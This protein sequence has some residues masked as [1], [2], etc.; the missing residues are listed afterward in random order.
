MKIVLYDLL[1]VSIALVVYILVN[2]VVAAY[3]VYFNKFNVAASKVFRIGSSGLIGIGAIVFIVFSVILNKFGGEIWDRL[4]FL[5]GIL[6]GAA[7]VLAA[8]WIPVWYPK[9]TKQQKMSVKSKFSLIWRNYIQTVCFALL[10]Y[11]LCQ[12]VNADRLYYQYTNTRWMLIFLAIA[13]LMNYSE[14]QFANMFS[15]GWLV[16]GILGSSAYLFNTNGDEQARMIARLNCGV[17]VAWGLLVVNILLMLAR[18]RKFSIN[19]RKDQI[20][21]IHIVLLFV[22]IVLMYINRFEKMW[23]YTAT[24]PFIALLFIK[25]K[26]TINI[27]FLKNFTNGIFLS[28]G[29]VTLF[30]VIH[31]PH[32]Y[33]MLYRYGGLFHTV[34]CTG[35]YLAVVFGAA[36]AKLYGKIKDRKKMFMRCPVEYFMVACAVSFILLTMSKTALFTTIMTVAAIVGL[37]AVAYHKNVRRIMAEIGVLACVCIISFPMVFTVV[38]TVPALINDPIRYDIEFQDQSFMVYEGDPIDSEKYMTVRRFFSLFFGRFHAETGK[39]SALGYPGIVLQEDSL[40]AY[41]GQSFAG[42]D[43]RTANEASTSEKTEDSWDVSNGRFEIFRAYLKEI[44][45]QG[46]PKM[47]PEDENGSEYA[48][49]HNSYLQVAYNFGV[50]AGCIFLVLCA[51]AL[52]KA[53]VLFYKQGR[54]FGILLVPFSLLVAFGVVSLTE[55]AFHP[56]IPLGFCFILMQ[57]FLIKT[58]GLL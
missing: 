9:Q 10:F 7:W 49:A 21:V 57:V 24:L 51:L 3:D 6:A 40:L 47:G 4:F 43:M 33:W 25:G 35:M 32:H 15:L 34:A 20:R 26:D 37:T 55:W 58:E 17:T 42:I 45:L 18:K 8:V 1:I 54:K 27:R 5:T 31:R 30:S 48:H 2:M 46:H 36:L 29:F 16:L 22:F 44:G 38:R 53:V 19:I 39:E 28:F 11:A 14:K 23:V 52:Y 41:T 12:Y 56:C 13:F 50:I